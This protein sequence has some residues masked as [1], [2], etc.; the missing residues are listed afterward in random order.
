MGECGDA[1]RG[2]Y[3]PHTSLKESKKIEIKISLSQSPVVPD[4]AETC[5]DDQLKQMYD[6]SNTGGD[7]TLVVKIQSDESEQLCASPEKERIEDIE[8]K[9]SSVILRSASKVL[10]VC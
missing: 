4:E 8:I 10:M 7:I 6:F 1:G 5:F 2:T 9:V 3:V